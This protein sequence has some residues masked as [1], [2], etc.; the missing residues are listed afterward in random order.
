MD[1]I[2]ALSY[3]YVGKDREKCSERMGEGAY[4]VIFSTV[5]SILQ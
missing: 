2:L 1:L 5:L 3:V 4:F